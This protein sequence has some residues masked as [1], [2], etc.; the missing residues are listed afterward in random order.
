MAYFKVTDVRVGRRT[1]GS[2]IARIDALGTGY[3]LPGVPEPP[4]VAAMLAV[5]ALRRDCYF[6]ETAH[7]FSTTTLEFPAGPSLITD[8]GRVA[9]WDVR[10]PDAAGSPPEFFVTLLADAEVRGTSGN[11]ANG[12]ARFPAGMNHFA[13]ALAL[14]TSRYCYYSNQGLRNTDIKEDIGW[15]GF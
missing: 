14:L 2:V 8:H 11:A 1:D 12:W 4:R 3:T 7:M 9:S 5:F 13:L 10:I 6:D 15:V